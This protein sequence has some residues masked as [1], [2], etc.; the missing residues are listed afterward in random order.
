MM[1]LTWIP[2]ELFPSGY[3]AG[4]PIVPWVSRLFEYGDTTYTMLYQQRPRAQQSRNEQKFLSLSAPETRGP[5][6][7]FAPIVGRPERF[8]SGRFGPQAGSDVAR[9]MAFPDRHLSEWRMNW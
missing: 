5:S 8:L 6:A 1:E 4:S 7:M 9:G 2:F 3:T